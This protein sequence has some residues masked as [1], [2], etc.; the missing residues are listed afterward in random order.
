MSERLPMVW[1]IKD[2]SKIEWGR[3]R[4]RSQPFA[5][6]RIDQYAF[7]PVDLSCILSSTMLYLR[8]FSLSSYRPYY[9]FIQM[10]VI[11]LLHDIIFVVP[12]KW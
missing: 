12:V 7:S 2:G 10:N 9:I 6:D 4:N 5:A 11:L 8:T 1:K 3:D